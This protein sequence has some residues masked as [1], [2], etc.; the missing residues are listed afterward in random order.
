MDNGEEAHDEIYCTSGAEE[1]VNPSIVAWVIVDV[2]F[3][4]G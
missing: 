2:G 4:K 1:V 3:E